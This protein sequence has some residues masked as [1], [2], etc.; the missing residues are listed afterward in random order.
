MYRLL[1]N[2]S[3]I[4]IIILHGLLIKIQNLFL[5]RI[6]QKEIYVSFLKYLV[7]YI[8]KNCVLLI[9]LYF[10]FNKLIHFKKIIC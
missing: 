1:R 7:I 6:F 10:T 8:E 9:L 2:K 4:N 5:D 3:I